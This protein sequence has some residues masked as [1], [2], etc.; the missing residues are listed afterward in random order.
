MYVCNIWN[1]MY[2]QYSI[3]EWVVGPEFDVQHDRSSDCG[4][5]GTEFR[6]SD[7]RNA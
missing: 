4:R 7:Y 5:G 1:N 2:V 6:F 3:S